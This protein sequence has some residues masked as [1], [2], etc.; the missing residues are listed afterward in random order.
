[1]S[2]PMRFHQYLICFLLALG[3]VSMDFLL[4]PR[5]SGSTAAAESA[6]QT[7]RARL[8]RQRFAFTDK[9]FVQSARDGRRV[10]VEQLSPRE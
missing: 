6:A 2:F 9:A 4:R 5:A 7:A 10:I 8:A 1:M 3:F